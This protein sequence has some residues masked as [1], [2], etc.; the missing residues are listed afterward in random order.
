MDVSEQQDAQPGQT[1]PQNTVDVGNERPATDHKIKLRPT[2][3]P[4]LD[5]LLGGGLP[6]HATVL[7]SGDAGVGKTTFAT[8]WLCNGFSQQEESGL[9]ITMT[10]PTVVTLKHLAAAEYYN[11]EMLASADMNASNI[12]SEY[13]KKQ[14]IHVVDM[15]QIMEELGLM[16]SDYS[17]EDMDKLHEVFAGL[18]MN[19]QVKRIVIDS[20]TAVAYLLGDPHKIRSFIFGFSKMLSLT[21]SNTL[22]ISEAKKGKDSVF[23]V[24]EFI[25]DG[26]INFTYSENDIHNTRSLKI[27]KLRGAHFNSAPVTYTI[28]SAGI[29]LYPRIAKR[30]DYQSSEVRL[31]TGIPGLDKITNGGFIKGS[32]IVING[33]SGGGKSLLSLQSLAQAVSAGETAVYFSLEE[34]KE[35]ILRNAKVFGWDLKPFVDSGKLIIHTT[36]PQELH[37]A[38]H[39]ASIAEIVN[40][41]LPDR[42]VVDSLSAV[43]GNYGLDSVHD[44][45]AQLMS[46]FKQKEITSIFLSASN[47]LVGGSDAT[48]FQISSIFDSIIMLRYVEIDA[49]FQHAVLVVKM[50]GTKHDKKLY[51]LKFTKQGLTVADSF[52]GYEGVFSGSARQVSKSKEEQ[53]QEVF[54]EVF[55]PMG[56]QLFQDQ[57]KKSLTVAGIGELAKE[58]ATEGILQDEKVDK[59]LDQVSNILEG[60]K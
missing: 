28:D 3:I 22:L 32:A 2:L 37:L 40:K 12:D 38:G 52:S 42:V 29:R 4:G 24:E 30:L 60:G 5:P 18:V 35:Q 43:E 1:G 20:I 58:L 47:S 36:H 6:A 17:Y 23:G 10:E 51:D 14:G 7:L 34:S 19:A 45:A 44:W 16:K 41:V 48:N 8:Q 13:A 50:R 26:V 33:P 27:K 57:K 9:Y 56:V 49:E 31:P 46:L 59:L 55:G 15:R 54:G 25:A 39:V 53:L 21:N 11:S